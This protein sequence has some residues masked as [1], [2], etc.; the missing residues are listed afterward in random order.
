VYRSK[1]SY[2]V[3]SSPAPG[4][5][6]REFVSISKYGQREAL[7]RAIEL[8]RRRERAI[9]GRAISSPS[10]SA[11]RSGARGSGRANSA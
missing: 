5:V 7:R 6:K 2:V 9:Y 11:K 1:K 3:A 10:A 8:R 4:Q